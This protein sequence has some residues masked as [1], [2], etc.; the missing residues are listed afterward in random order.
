MGAG[1]FIAEVAQL[2]GGTALVDAR[3]IEPVSGLKSV[4]TNDTDEC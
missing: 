3:A 2:S 1:E 4:P